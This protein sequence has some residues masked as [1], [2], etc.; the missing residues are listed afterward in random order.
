MRSL[1]EIPNKKSN[2]FF[3]CVDAGVNKAELE[4]LEE[5]MR[6]YPEISLYVLNYKVGNKFE[7]PS[8]PGILPKWRG[9]ETFLQ[10]Y[11]KYILYF[12]H[13]REGD[14]LAS[15]II[16]TQNPLFIEVNGEKILLASY[17]EYLVLNEMHN[18][19]EETL[20]DK[21]FLEQ[22]YAQVM[23]ITLPTIVIYFLN[24]LGEI[25]Q[26]NY[27]QELTNKFVNLCFKALEHFHENNPR[28]AHLKDKNN[29]I[30]IFLNK[31]TSAQV[32]HKT[33]EFF[34]KEKKV[35]KALFKQKGLIWSASILK[36]KFGFGQ[37]NYQSISKLEINE[38]Q[39]INDLKVIE[40]NRNNFDHKSIEENRVFGTLIRIQVIC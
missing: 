8:K 6:R 20:E 7:M 18:V 27:K 11:V 10:V 24:S 29:Q 37:K 26:R 3:K 14:F 35:P 4:C 32:F 39:L 23:W 1:V 15:W 9:D 30:Y 36:E 25:R 2:E 21:D 5:L 34:R 38:Q 31:L 33:K 40:Q 19:L 13:L 22:A 28:S 12:A 17:L 16:N